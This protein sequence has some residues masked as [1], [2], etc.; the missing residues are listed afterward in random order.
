MIDTPR[1]SQSTNVHGC[2]HDILQ[3]LLRCVRKSVVTLCIEYKQV[4]Q[5]LPRMNSVQ[6]VSSLLSTSLVYRRTCIQQC[7]PSHELPRKKGSIPP[8]NR[9]PHL[10]RCW[11]NCQS[12][13]SKYPNIP[14]VPSNSMSRNPL[15]LLVTHTKQRRSQYELSVENEVQTSVFL[16]THDNRQKVAWRGSLSV[17][18]CLPLYAI[19]RFMSRKWP[20]FYCNPSEC[21]C[22]LICS[23]V[24]PYILYI[25]PSFQYVYVRG[26]TGP[27]L[28]GGW[29]RV[30]THSMERAIEEETK[31][32]LVGMGVAPNLLKGDIRFSCVGGKQSQAA[33]KSSNG[34][35]TAEWIYYLHT[36]EKGE[37]QQ[38]AGR[39]GP[40]NNDPR[41]QRKRLGRARAPYKSVQL[42][43][44]PPD[45]G[46]NRTAGARKLTC[47]R[48]G[49]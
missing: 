18:Q 19:Y 6:A 9:P 39:G 40:N 41:S 28:G 34:A 36:V 14:H 49:R 42:A 16:S 13:D 5:L 35:R 11:F 31:L 33:S 12:I 24:G 3:R 20:L 23:T 46:I 7:P 38:W 45:T 15:G 48:I 10:R 44:G 21:V 26:N 25:I 32:G 1:K 22:M 43:D 4:L 29:G 47:V 30:R 27:G 8:H 37:R 17:S 2:K